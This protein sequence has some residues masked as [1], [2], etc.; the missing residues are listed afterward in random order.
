MLCHEAQGSKVEP[1]RAN[2]GERAALRG[3]VSL[4]TPQ[5][6]SLGNPLSH[7]QGSPLSKPYWKP[8]GMGTQMILPTPVSPP[9][10]RAGRKV[11]LGTNKRYPALDCFPNVFSNNTGINYP[12]RQVLGMENWAP[13]QKEN[14]SPF[15]SS[16]FNATCPLY[17]TLG[18]LLDI[19]LSDLCQAYQP[20]LHG[21][22]QL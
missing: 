18:W 17:S 9:G 15:I 22:Q 13:E 11:G 6:G 8:E 19:G 10:H 20:L 12:K 16:V 14:G 21:I 1:G 4:A 5:G 7:L 2:P 3:A